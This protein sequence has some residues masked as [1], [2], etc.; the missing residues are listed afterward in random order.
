MTPNLSTS[1]A[2]SYSTVRIE[3]EYKNGS[4][5]S[6]TGFF[7]KIKED[8]LK[9]RFVPILITNKHV[10]KDSVKGE[11]IITKADAENCPL[12][13]QHFHA[14]IIDFESSWRN[15]PDDE[16]D[17]C[18]MPVAEIR[19]EATRKGEKIFYI[20]LDKS[21]IPS[22]QNLDEFSALEDI[23]MIG[24]PDNIWDFVN[25]K[26]I[27]RKG[28]TAIHP[29]Y[30]Y[31]GKKWTVIDMA[32]FP[33]SS[34]SPVFIY[35]ETGYSDKFG[36]VTFGQS[37]FILLGILFAGPQHS[38]EGDIFINNLPITNGPKVISRIPNNLGYIIK[39]ERILE[40][41]AL[42]NDQQ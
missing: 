12:D 1:E 18:A 28:I 19:K 36:N 38:I 33:G 11:L 2:L 31:C 27:F 30:D 8:N 10:I 24:Y 25:N 9:N 17:L 32:C 26:P 41:E 5:G 7:F 40:L 14:N 35:N 13:T 22:S 16:V 3:C 29:K 20:P 6:G 4:K 42:F 23:F 15:H 37:R 34:G 39:S 21:V